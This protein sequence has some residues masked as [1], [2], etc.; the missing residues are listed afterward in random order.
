MTVLDNILLGRHLHMKPSVWRTAL[1]PWLARPEEVA[2]REVVDAIP[3]GLKNP[4][5]AKTTI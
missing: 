3:P 1:Y 4:E 2:H 5:F